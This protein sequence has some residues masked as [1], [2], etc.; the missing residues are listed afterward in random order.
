MEDKKGKTVHID[1]R[2]SEKYSNPLVITP[3]KKGRSIIGE[4]QELLLQDGFLLTS[5]VQRKLKVD[6]NT[7]AEVMK[8]LKELGMITKSKDSHAYVRA[9]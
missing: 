2:D 9:K 7:A 1:L 6:Y 3:S 4:A 8:A 5:S